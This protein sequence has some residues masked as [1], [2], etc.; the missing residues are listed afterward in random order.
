MTFEEAV[1]NTL[2]N[3]Q[4]TL[5]TISLVVSAIKHGWPQRRKDE[6]YIRGTCGDR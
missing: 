6:V 1:E 5:D 2:V 4:P 3:G